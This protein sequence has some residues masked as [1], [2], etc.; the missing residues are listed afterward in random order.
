MSIDI[1]YIKSRSLN[2]LLLIMHIKRKIK[3]FRVLFL[4]TRLYFY[5]LIV[6]Q[7]IFAN[8]SFQTSNI[9]DV[10]SRETPAHRTKLK[11]VKSL[12]N[13]TAK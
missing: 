7:N 3:Q 11:R 13:K 2:V 5:F 4:R 6:Y 10:G 9:L 12:S 8:E 1:I